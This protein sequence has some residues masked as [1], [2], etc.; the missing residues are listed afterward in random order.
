MKV[1]EAKL[2]ELVKQY[3]VREITDKD[4]NG[5]NRYT[6]L[7]RLHFPA[8]DKPKAFEDGGAA[9]YSGCFIIDPRTDIKPLVNGAK[10]AAI[11]K[12]GADKAR[13]LSTTNNEHGVPLLRMPFRKQSVKKAAGEDGFG[14][15]GYFFNASEGTTWPDG[16][17]KTPPALYD[18]RM[19][20]LPQD[21]NEL[22]AGC[23][24]LVRV[25][26]FGY[27]NKGNTGVSVALQA[28]QKI[29]DGERLR[30]TKADPGDGFAPIGGTEASA[31]SLADANADW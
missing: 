10:V 28:L 3:P 20:R 18:A 16:S 25:S 26:F 19:Q 1:N 12:F 29:G 30:T 2:A 8:L 17:A 6:V 15:D 24:V 31:P 27:S 21:T 4:G 23:Y 14:D 13:T 7:A 5:T 9:K 22:Y 11:A